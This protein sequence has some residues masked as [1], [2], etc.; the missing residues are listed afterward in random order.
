MDRR[1]P[2]RAARGG[3]DRPLSPRMATAMATD[4]PTIGQPP[5]APRRPAF[6]EAPDCFFASS[7]A[8][9]ASSVDLAMGRLLGLPDLILPILV[10]RGL[11]PHAATAPGAGKAE[12][13]EEP[14]RPDEP[15]DSHRCLAPWWPLEVRGFRTLCG[16][17]GEDS[18]VKGIEDPGRGSS[19]P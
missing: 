12:H 13:Q 4:R 15:C 17:R 14:Q 3:E 19:F 1:H 5:V 8:C 11:G 2:D 16:E 18:V 9:L 6:R 10:D 7:W